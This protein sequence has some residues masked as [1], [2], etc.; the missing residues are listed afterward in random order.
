MMHQYDKFEKYSWQN[1]VLFANF[2]FV[3]FHKRK[4]NF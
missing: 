3:S 2:S 1:A 4:N